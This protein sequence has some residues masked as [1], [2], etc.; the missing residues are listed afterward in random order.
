M[1]V[2]PNDAILGPTI[3]SAAQALAYAAGGHRPAD[4]AAYLEEVYRLGPLTG[5]N[6]ILIC[7]AAMDETARFT[8]RWW[9]ERLNAGSLGVTGDPVQDEASPTFADGAASARA[10]VAHLL[11]YA[12]GTIDRGGLTP[13]DDPRHDAYVAAYGAVA[14]ATT[15]DALGG[16]YA[17]NPQY[18]AQI[19]AH[20]N[21]ILAMPGGTPMPDTLN[22]KPGLVPFPPF[23]DSLVLDNETNAYDLLGK[24]VVCAFVLHRMLG[25]RDSTAQYFH[26]FAPGLTE[27]GQDAATGAFL[28]WNDP[29]GAAHP[30]VSADRSPWASGVYNVN[31]DAY[32]DGPKLVARFGVNGVNRNALAWEIDGFY[33]DPWS[34]AAM[35]VAAQACAA[36]AHDYGIR[37]DTFPYIPDEDRNFT[38]WHQEVTGPAE[39]I[40]PGPVVMAQTPAF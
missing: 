5:M 19:A 4:V 32:G 26:N 7:A 11:L 37:W 16:T 27:L 25:G 23:T 18:G 36:N 9:T 2:T 33:G 3:G 14:R 31:G 12:T 29:D 39:K 15:L 40:C 34:D 8:N 24:K 10:H 20:A 22:M 6:A 35:L 38:I 21:A 17:A 13:A 30:G 28:R 1:T